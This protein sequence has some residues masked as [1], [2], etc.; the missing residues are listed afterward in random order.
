MLR[1]GFIETACRPES[2]KLVY[3]LG[4]NVL[5]Q[6]HNGQFIKLTPQSFSRELINDDN[7]ENYPILYKNASL[8]LLK[9]IPSLTEIIY[10]WER[11]NILMKYTYDRFDKNH[12]NRIV[13]SLK[14]DIYTNTNYFYSEKYLKTQEGQLYLIP[15]IEKNIDAI[16]IALCYLKTTEGKPLFF[17][18]SNKKTIKSLDFHSILPFVICRALILCD[19]MILLNDGIYHGKSCEINNVSKEHII[20]LTR[21]FNK[22]AVRESDE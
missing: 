6:T 15:S 21:I 2:G 14:Q 19:P 12:F 13:D 4:K 1:T 7:V 5:V 8:A 18:N 22:T 11:S 3:C 17:Y 9:R 10:H 16:N 20:E